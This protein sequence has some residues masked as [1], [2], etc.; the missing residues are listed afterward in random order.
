MCLAESSLK[1]KFHN[2]FIVIASGITSACLYPYRTSKS[3]SGFTDIIEL[4]SNPDPDPKHYLILKKLLSIISRL[5]SK[6][7]QPKS[8]YLRKIFANVQWKKAELSQYV[9]GSVA[10]PD[11]G[12]G[13]RCLF[14]PW[15]RDPGWE[16]VSIRIRDPGSTTRII[17]F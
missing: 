16:K 12:S 9:Y 7:K 11:P 2:F 8:I 13:I 4:G 1:N 10:D 14:D 3:G 17:F 6:G 15:I 5:W